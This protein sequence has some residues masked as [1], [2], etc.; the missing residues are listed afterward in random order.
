MHIDSIKIVYF[1][2]ERMPYYTNAKLNA[3][4]NAV[5]QAHKHKNSN[6]LIG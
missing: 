4:V 1:G 6:A 3:T 2:R 5:H